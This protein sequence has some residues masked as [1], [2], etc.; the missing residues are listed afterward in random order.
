MSDI[1]ANS[2]KLLKAVNLLVSPGGATI[3]G[4]GNELGISRRSVFRFLNFLE[5]MGFPI[6]D[7]QSVS[8]RIKV[9]RLMDSFV[10]KLP[11]IAIPN[12]RFSEEEKQILLSLLESGVSLQL[13][14]SK[15]MLKSIRQ[16][17]RQGF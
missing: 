7:E 15:I 14:K 13:I 4:L 10:L 16:K 5:E 3:K 12:P 1:Y 17:L 6:Y 11:N 9:Y 2:V 8:E